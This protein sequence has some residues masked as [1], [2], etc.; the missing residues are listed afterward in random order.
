MSLPELFP[1][2]SAELSEGADV[3]GGVVAVVYD[4]DTVVVTVVEVV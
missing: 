2:L 1:E 3:T 4:G